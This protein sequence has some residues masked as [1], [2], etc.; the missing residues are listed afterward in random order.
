ME[1]PKK[2]PTQ[3]LEEI[4]RRIS[5]IQQE[6]IRA[7]DDLDATIR[8][9]RSPESLQEIA[10]ELRNSI[11]ELWLSHAGIAVLLEEQHKD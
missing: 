2:Q 6:V 11:S 8:G 10:G 9:A 3:S 4:N 5:E 7:L 1:S